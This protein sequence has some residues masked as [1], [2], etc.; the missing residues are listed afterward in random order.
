VTLYG[1]RKKPLAA[2]IDR[3]IRNVTGADV[4]DGR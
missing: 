1:K 2:E 3:G 4:D